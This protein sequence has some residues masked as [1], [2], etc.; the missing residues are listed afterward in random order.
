[1]IHTIVPLEQVMQEPVDSQRAPTREVV[2]NGITME[3][4]PIDE[5]QARIV[6]IFSPRP[7][8]YLN[9]AYMPGTVFN[10]IS[11]LSR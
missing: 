1:M 2:I 7:N 4:E 6:R 5:Q 10:W 9:P 11:D 3:I 8:D